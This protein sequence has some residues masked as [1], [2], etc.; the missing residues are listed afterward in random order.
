MQ[1]DDE[2]ASAYGDSMT[3]TSKELKKMDHAQLLDIASKFLRL[4]VD[5]KLTEEELLGRIVREATNI[6]FE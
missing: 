4:D 2:R 3:L 6:S 1:A 5:K